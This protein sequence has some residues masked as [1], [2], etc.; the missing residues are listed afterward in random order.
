MAANAWQANPTCGGM[1]GQGGQEAGPEPGKPESLL[2]RMD[3]DGKLVIAQAGDHPLPDA[4]P[5]P[6][7]GRPPHPNRRPY[8]AGRQ[9]PRHRRD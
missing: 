9:P 7:R 4:V 3:R 5:P 6:R 1:A 8:R 2:P